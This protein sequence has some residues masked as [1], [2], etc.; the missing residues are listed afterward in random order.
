MMLWLSSLWRNVVHRDRT[1]DDLDDEVRGTL[2]MLIAEKME[3]GMRADEA[4]RAATLELGGVEQVKEQIRG[5]R[6][7]ALLDGSLQDLR[8]GVRTLIKRPGF[9]TVA[10]T[11]LAVGIASCPRG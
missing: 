4:R 8:Y 9:T 6:A 2:D 3:A 10:V 1:E 7:G 5:T 11:T